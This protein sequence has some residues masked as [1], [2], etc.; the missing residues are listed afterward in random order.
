MKKH[1]DYQLTAL[2]I[3]LLLP[4][5]V[6]A[7]DVQEN[8]VQKT[9]ITFADVTARYGIENHIC[10]F[11]AVFSDID[12]DGRDDLIVSNHGGARPS[13]YLNRGGRFEDRTLSLP[14][15]DIVDMH[16]IT[17]VDIDNDGDKDV[18]IA[19]GGSLGVGHGSPNQIFRNLLAE[20]GVLSFEEVAAVV[21]VAW[22]KWRGRSFIPIA[23][24]GGGALDFYF[25]CRP[26]KG[27]SSVYL[28]NKSDGDIRLEPDHGHGIDW[29]RDQKG[30]GD[31]F[32]DFDRDGD[33]DLI[34]LDAE[35]I[36]LFENKGR[37]FLRKQASFD[38]LERVLSLGVGDLNGDGYPD[39]YVGTRPQNSGS[40]HV[41]S[42]E[43]N[44]LSRINFVLSGNG[45]D[46]VDRI[47]FKS[48]SAEILL[49]LDD[50]RGMYQRSLENIHIGRRNVHPGSLTDL[51]ITRSEAMG[52]PQDRGPGTY[53]WRTG[54]NLWAFEWRYRARTDEA[55]GAVIADKISA[56]IPK[57]IE[58]FAR[59]TTRDRIFINRQG[60]GF[61]ELDG[62]DLSHDQYTR[63][64]AFY[65]LDNDGNVDIVG[66]RG[67][68][69]GS[70]NGEP[71]ILVNR[72][73]AQPIFDFRK[74]T[75][76]G[77]SDDDL[78]QA[79]Q[80]T[81]GFVNGDGLPDLFV[82]N[83]YG[84]LPGSRGPYK[85]FINK[86]KTKNNYALLAL[87]GVDSVR[88]AIGAQVSL[89]TRAGDF[90]GYRELGVVHNRMQHSH[91]IHFGLGKYKGMLKADIL[92]PN[93][94]RQS[95]KLKPNR[96]TFVREKTD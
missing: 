3:I 85:L 13:V 2:L 79:D 58:T 17:V 63:A 61:E 9:V 72:G 96:L 77:N 24:S 93:G 25:V 95:V 56:V 34:I 4:P 36:L 18:L 21:G 68:E 74:K 94:K 14:I 48:P 57:G 54:K 29:K 83:G 37:R 76:L 40:D 60:E 8:D 35:T 81:V 41:C 64:L 30:R 86:T 65:D 89:Y 73:G 69:P 91:K 38:R 80:L 42:G 12:N 46:Q 47:E 45:G 52:T 16:G 10:T 22:Q 7:A 82:T 15:T 70:I 78:S 75:G 90:L 59:H 84:Q 44:G 51:R 19:G 49:E 27:T 1:R 87:E 31:F 23:G 55:R 50:G 67:S 71:F 62:I 6:Y 43:Q 53:I 5:A 28:V 39:I 20:T 11:G 26:R 88:D 66:I 33:R 32:F 92:W